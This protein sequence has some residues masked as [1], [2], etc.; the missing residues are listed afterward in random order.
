MIVLACILMLMVL[1][2]AAA[3]HNCNR[4]WKNRIVD[5]QF[6]TFDDM[7]FCVRRIR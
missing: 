6:V 3:H 7:S 4:M 1:T 2:G 5:N